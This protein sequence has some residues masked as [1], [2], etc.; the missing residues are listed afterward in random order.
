MEDVNETARRLEKI[1]HEIV[2]GPGTAEKAKDRVRSYFQGLKDQLNRQEVAA[3]TVVDTYIRERLCFIR[4]HEE[5]IE[6][7]SNQVGLVC[8]HISKA[9]KQDDARVI[10]AAAEMRQMM[11]TVETQQKQFAE[12][13]NETLIP[14]ASIPITFTKDNRVHIGPKIEM[15][16]VTLGLDGSGKTSILFKLKQNEFV[17]CIPTIGF[18]VESL[19]YK[20]VKFT[21][22]DV[23][24]QPKL[25]PLWKHYYLNTQAVVFVIDSSNP[26]RLDEAQNELVKLIAEKELKDAFILILLNKQ[27]C[28]FTF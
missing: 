12:I 8:A 24:G 2:T 14:D 1:Q 18:N 5:D 27:V 26:E 6:M 23:G 25:R 28:F 3:L 22:W 4:Q 11:E 20:N 13:D 9:I 7:I 19:E 15:R 17:Q 16:V 21:I 10:C